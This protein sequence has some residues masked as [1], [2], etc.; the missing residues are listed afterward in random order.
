MWFE[1]EDMTSVSFSYFKRGNKHLCP[2]DVRRFQKYVENQVKGIT[3]LWVPTRLVK[4]L[5]RNYYNRRVLVS[6]HSGLK[7]VRWTMAF[8]SLGRAGR[9]WNLCFLAIFG[10]CWTSTCD[11]DMLSLSF[12][13]LVNTQQV[14]D[15][16]QTLN[17]GVWRFHVAVFGTPTDGLLRIQDSSWF[18]IPSCVAPA[19]PTVWS[20]DWSCSLCGFLVLPG[21]VVEDKEK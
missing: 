4:P 3:W 1:W 6:Q 2:E 7:I 9:S 5:T 19:V 21:V 18:A 16:P 17:Q 13:H 12:Q 20:W 11:S 15:K 14:I 8:M 10:R